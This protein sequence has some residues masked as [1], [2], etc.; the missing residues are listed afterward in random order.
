[1]RG[2][3]SAERRKVYVL[4]MKCYRSLVGVSRVD[5]VRYEEV[6][7]TALVHMYMIEL[8][9]AMFA[10]ALSYFGPALW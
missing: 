2:M 10:L 7:W 6:R 8:N 9:A 1:M 5:I 4:E 3:R